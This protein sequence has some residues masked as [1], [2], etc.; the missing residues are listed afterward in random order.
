MLL[1][2]ANPEPEATL[3]AKTGANKPR[4]IAVTN[5]STLFGPDRTIAKDD[6]PEIKLKQILQKP[7]VRKD[8]AQDR[9][10]LTPTGNKDSTKILEIMAHSILKL[11][12]LLGYRGMK[13]TAG[14]FA[15]YTLKSFLPRKC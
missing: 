10:V 5:I 13:K 4:T 11:L 2:V 3:T 8:T 15:S 1:K 9:S 7:R 12:D 14:T 6:K